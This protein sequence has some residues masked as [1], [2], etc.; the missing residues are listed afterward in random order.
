MLMKF[1]MVVEEPRLDAA[2]TGMVSHRLPWGKAPTTIPYYVVRRGVLALVCV[3]F[4]F[5]LIS[6]SEDLFSCFFGRP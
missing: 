4:L 6:L 2:K 3:E 5:D 1:P